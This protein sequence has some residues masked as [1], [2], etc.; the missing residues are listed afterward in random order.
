MSD[1]NNG[2]C[3]SGGNVYKTTNGGTNWIIVN[4]TPGNLFA[5]VVKTFSAN[6]VYIGSDNSLF[7]TTDG[8]V[9]WSEKAFS[10]GTL[11][12]MDWT[13]LNNGT[14]VGVEGFTG[15]T[16][17]GGDSWTFRNTG[18]STIK[19]VSMVSSDTVY[20]S[21]NLNDYGALFRLVDANTSITLNLT[22]GIQG[23]WNGTTQVSDTVDIHLM[24]SVSPYNEIASVSGVLNTNGQGTFIFNSAPS[25]SYY[26]KIT[27]R[28]SLETWNASPVALSTGGSL[29]Y[30]FTTAAS[31]AYGNNTILTSGRYCDYSGDVTQE[32]SVD[33]NDVVNVNNASSVFTTGYVVQDVTGDNLVDLSDLIITFNNASMFVTKISP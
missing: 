24:N 31:Q 33:L 15:R 13:D 22:I 26:I 25:G 32:G 9:T 6:I 27:H 11:R 7:K 4:N 10:M 2:Y 5:N 12:G 29:N 17:N 1:A 8:G 28:N 23:F 19:G 14:I 30:N 21:C 18:T 3:A 20:A 16:T